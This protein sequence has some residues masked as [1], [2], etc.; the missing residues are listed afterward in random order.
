MLLILLTAFISCKDDQTEIPAYITIE[1]I[2]LDENTYTNI[3]NHNITDAW[4]YI[5][6]VLQ[7]VY[8]LPA[9]FPLLYEGE[10][11]L[12]IRAGIKENGIAGTRIPYPFYSSFIIDNQIF[13]PEESI[14]LNPE[15][16]YIEGIDFFIEDF[17]GIGIDLET[18]AMSDTSIIKFDDGYNK[19]GAGIL[20]DSLI[21]F[22]I[23]TEA[24]DKL[25]QAGAPVYLEMNYKSNT[26]FLIG[27]YVNFPQNILQKDLLWVNPKQDWNKI[28]INLTSS[29][30]E[31]VN[32]D[33]FKVFISMRRDFSV[34][35]NSIYL[36][37]VKVVY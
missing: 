23:T 32:A 17:E 12:R 1:E 25:P 18:T 8:E 7:G 28:Y 30:S 26:P 31:S 3:P 9:N 22:E 27:L 36:D 34:D 21:N 35:T 4:V 33:F 14:S 29:V 5:D 10:H 20:L 6:E 24:L 16:E 37:D 15:V 19:Y 13:N 11:K 2:K